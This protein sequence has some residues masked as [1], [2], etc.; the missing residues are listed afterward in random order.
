[1]AD[2][3]QLGFVRS[4]TPEQVRA[5]WREHPPSALGHDRF[6]FRLEDESFN[7]LTWVARYYD[8][9]QKVLIVCS[10]GLVL[11]FFREFLQSSFRVT[12][13]FEADGHT[14]TRVTLLGHAHPRTR[15]ALAELAAENG[16]TVGLTVGV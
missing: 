13:H 10:L 7:S 5:E 4:G 12:A 16:G 8:W 2:E 6:P 1:V 14:R 15:E 3:I 11:L 9:P